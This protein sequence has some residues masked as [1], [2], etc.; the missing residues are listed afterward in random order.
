MRGADGGKL[1]LIG[2]GG[3]AKVVADLILRVGSYEIVGFLDD[4][5]ATWGRTILGLPV[6]GGHERLPALRAEGAARCLV[7]VGDNR[8]R[9]ALAEQAAA[10]GYSFPVA[11][12][13]RATVAPS[14]RLGPG[15][16]VAAAA[17][18][19]PEAV[20]GNHAIINT[21]AIVEHDNRLG[22]GVHISPGAVLCGGVTVGDHGHVGAGARVIPGVCVGSDCVIGAGAV[23]IR[24]LPDRVVAVGVP[25]RV[26]K[27]VAP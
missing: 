15:T 24:D 4:D 1:V 21:G 27:E 2:A 13:P 6:L 19:N 5:P 3:H 10:L 25:A 17:V 22:E 20:V 14:A 18:V 12:H 7:A 8:A 16:V 11:I 26:I 23:V 9:L